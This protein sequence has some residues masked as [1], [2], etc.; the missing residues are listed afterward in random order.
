MP[1]LEPLI[2][3]DQIAARIATLADEIRAR[4][5]DHPLLLVGVMK[6]SFLFH[7]DLVRALHDLDVRIDF[8]G[9]HSYAGTSSTG[10][11]RLT[12]DLKHSIDGQHVVLVEDI[13]DTGL[14]MRFLFDHLSRHS[15]ASLEVA[16]LLDKPSRRKV[17]FIPDYIG[18]SIPDAFVVG[19]G[20][21]LDERYRNLPDVR[22]YTP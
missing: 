3:A 15:P 8:L 9:V 1:T 4:H 6:G 13:V 7:A 21:D 22:V 5:H 17:E 11:V 10:A 20:L 16:T 19:Y 18:F 12:N 14:T 2:P